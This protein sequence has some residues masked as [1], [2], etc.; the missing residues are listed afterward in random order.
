MNY[1]KTLGA[2]CRSFLERN[3][4]RG[5]RRGNAGTVQSEEPYDCPTLHTVPWKTPI[6][7]A[8]PTSPH[9]LALDGMIH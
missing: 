4:E 2:T 5:A 1:W 7:P 9:P 6:L 8:S 3:T